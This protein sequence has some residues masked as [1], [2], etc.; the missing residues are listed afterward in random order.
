MMIHREIYQRV[1]DQ[2]EPLE[3]D[4]PWSRFEAGVDLWRLSAD[5]QELVNRLRHPDSN[6]D[7]DI[8]PNDHPDADSGGNA[9]TYSDEDL[10]AS[11]VARGRAKGRLIP[12][13]CLTR[14]TN[15]VVPLRAQPAEPPFDLLVA[16]DTVTGRLPVCAALHDGA[17][18]A[19]IEKTGCLLVT[20]SIED[21]VALRLAGLPA[22]TAAGLPNLA[23]EALDDFCKSYGLRESAN[24]TNSS[25][26]VGGSEETESE[27]LSPTDAMSQQDSHAPGATPGT[28][29]AALSPSAPPRLVFVNWKPSTLECTSP[30]DVE[31]LR[32][33]FRQLETFLE[34]SLEDMFLWTPTQED[35]DRVR[36][37]LQA[38]TLEDVQTSLHESLEQRLV[39]I[40]SVDDE[41]PVASKELIDVM[42][43]LRRSLR[44]RGNRNRVKRHWAEFEAKFGKLLV[45]PMIQRALA[46]NDPALRTYLFAI[47]EINQI[48]HPAAE[49]VSASL[50]RRI[51]SH[52]VRRAGSTL[53]AEIDPLLKL[54]AVLRKLLKEGK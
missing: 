24:S 43:R 14:P 4:G 26:D 15:I 29:E 33:R 2:C 36:F 40:T 45:T 28:G 32:Q 46:E 39:E 52:G 31:Q 44:R 5:P 1:V 41:P 34:L 49:V 51:A 25:P 42:N 3:V 11:R 9:T 18:Q 12:N 50:A 23:L 6:D 37:C 7:S 10:L 54:F 27:G 22:I 48:I 21:L 17:L 35:I 20:F 8:D 38:A 19:A 13:S 53:K 16:D 47:A 30:E